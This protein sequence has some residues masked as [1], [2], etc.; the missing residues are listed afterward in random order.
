MFGE[1]WEGR[2]GRG[3]E[4]RE[5]GFEFGSAAPD[6]RNDVLRTPSSTLPLPLFPSHPPLVIFL[7]PSSS[8][9]SRCG[10]RSEHRTRVPPPLIYPDHAIRRRWIW[11]QMLL[12]SR[13]SIS[14]CFL[15]TDATLAR[16][17]PVADGSYVIKSTTA[18][19]IFNNRTIESANR[20]IYMSKM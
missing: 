17:L 16:T 15:D 12:H 8:P 20:N 11:S 1:R 2:G 3:V 13:R 10:V 6:V 9:K 4:T 7:L 5:F 14:P 18:R 19:A